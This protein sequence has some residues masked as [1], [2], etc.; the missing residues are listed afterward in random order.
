MISEY[1]RTQVLIQQNSG[2]RTIQELRRK[3]AKEDLRDILVKLSSTNENA[4]AL[5]NIILD[6]L[7]GE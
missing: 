3:E 5:F 7:I 4:A 2:S 1:D 6:P